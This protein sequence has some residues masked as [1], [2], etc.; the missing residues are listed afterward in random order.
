MP[1]DSLK[2]SDPFVIIVTLV[3]LID[4]KAANSLVDVYATLKEEMCESP[5][6]AWS[7][8]TKCV[9]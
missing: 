4:V 1:R 6:V 2:S 8:E 5:E 3:D 9:H 7:V